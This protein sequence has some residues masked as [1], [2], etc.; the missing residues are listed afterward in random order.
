[1][2]SPQRIVHTADA[3][4]WLSENGPLPGCSLI[5]SLPDYSEFPSLSLGEWKTWFETAAERT[6][7]ACPDDGVTLFFQSDIKHEGEWV[8]KAFLVQK[9]AERLGH[10]QL[11]HKIVCRLPA[12][13]TTYGRPGYSHLLAFSKGI[14]ADPARSTADVLPRLGEMSWARGMGAEAC[15]AAIRFV[16]SHTQSRTIVN[17]FCGQG[18]VLATANELGL[19]AI[20]IDKSP[21]QS[22]KARTIVSTAGRLHFDKTL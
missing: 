3:L 22:R 10:R 4:V 1:M 13:Q 14:K 2:E 20:G 8:D 7:A 9:A 15:L 5:A 18:S 11:W 12:G 16:L 21:K 17:P 6:L 19:N